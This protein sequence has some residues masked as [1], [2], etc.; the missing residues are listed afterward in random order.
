LPDQII[1]RD[2]PYVVVEQMPEYPG[3]DRELLNFI[4][5]NTRYPEEAKA[6]KIEGRVIVR[7]IVST[8]G[9]AEDVTVLKGVHPLLDAEAV[10]VISM[11]TGFEPGM[12]G[13]KPVNV[14]YMAPITFSLPKPESVK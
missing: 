5:N 7:F 6:Q 12:Q 14:W 1:V 13:G 10:R 2:E 8:D 11:M 3:G 9:N 4:E